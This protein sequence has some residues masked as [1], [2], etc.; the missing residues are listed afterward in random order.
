[1]MRSLYTASTGMYAQQL[2][3]DT[4]AHNMSNVNTAGYKK[5]RVEFQDLL[6]QIIKR[7]AATEEANQPV[8]LTVGLGVKPVAI[9][10]LFGQGNLQQTENP[11]DVSITGQAFFKIQV[12]GYEDPL[13]SRD[14]SFKL[15][16]SGQ[17][18]TADGNLVIGAEPIEEGATDVNIAKDGTVTYLPLGSTTPEEAGKIELSKFVN[19][20]GLQKVGANLYQATP[21]S[22]EPVDWDSESDSSVKLESGY[23]EMANV[24][25][26]EEMVSLITAQRAYDI[27]SKVIQASD[28]MLQTATSLRR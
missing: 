16:G 6:Y 23:L 3:V 9:N 22:G 7:P 2:N 27:N 1:M 11:L 28:E 25:V 18:V 8:G 13:Y 14:G 20:A 19:P 24:K 12:P 10:T 4:I 26:V 21:N 17:M 15:D 5:E